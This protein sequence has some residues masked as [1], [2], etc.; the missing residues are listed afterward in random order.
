MLLRSPCALTI[1]S[2]SPHSNHPLVSLF[3]C[4]C[5]F[6][7]HS[8]CVGWQVL[9]CPPRWQRLNCIRLIN[10]IRLN[11]VQA[12][13][14]LILFRLEKYRITCW[15]NKQDS[16][17]CVLLYTVVCHVD[18]VRHSRAEIKINHGKWIIKYV[19]CAFFS[20]SVVCPLPQLETTNHELIE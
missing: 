19:F 4:V 17:S 15:H 18:C 5:V 16:Y 6:C 1:S 2:A 13:E 9:L 7:V 11:N 10:I 8:F 20:S 3:F 12:K 14:K